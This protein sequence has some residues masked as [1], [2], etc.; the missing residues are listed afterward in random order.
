[1]FYIKFYFIE[2]ESTEKQFN[3]FFPSNLWHS[4]ATSSMKTK[5]VFLHSVQPKNIIIQPKIKTAIQQMVFFVTDRSFAMAKVNFQ[6][7]EV[8]QFNSVWQLI[9]MTFAFI[10][11]YQRLQQ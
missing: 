5:S 10:S 3:F 8:I 11:I 9:E 4:T 1:M 2:N 6:M 7:F